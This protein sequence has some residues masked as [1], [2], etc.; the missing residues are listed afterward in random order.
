MNKAERFLTCAGIGAACIVGSFL[1]TSVAH[2]PA[3]AAAPYAD[4][5]SKIAI[6]DLLEVSEKLFMSPR[7]MPTRETMLKEKQEQIK[8]LQTSLQELG[9][10]IQA[11]GQNSP[12]AQ[13]LI[14]QYQ[15]QNEEFTKTRESANKDLDEL[16]TQQFSEAYRLVVETAGSVAKKQGFGYVF[17]TRSGP[18]QFRS[19]QLQGALQ[20]VL[21]RPVVMAPD[22]VDITTAVMKELKL[23]EV[24]PAVPAPA[25]TPTPAPAPAPAAPPAKK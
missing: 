21:A 1:A 14:Q 19:T 20:E 11:M 25:E 13:A 7:Y 15:A 23:D 22:G 8:T 10:K 12:D 2:T 3:F 24:K 9:Q 6:V 17:A 4:D 16:S 5:S 18:L